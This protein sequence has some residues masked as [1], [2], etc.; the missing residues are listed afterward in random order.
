MRLIFGIVF[1]VGYAFAQSGI[2][3]PKIGSIIDS[4]GS[5]RSVQ[6]VAGSFSLGAVSVPEVLS[7]ACSEHLCLAK[8]DS[9]ILSPTGETDA[10]PGPAIFA[11]NGDAATMYFAAP[12]MFAQWAN[13]SMDPLEW[14]IEGDVLSLLWRDGAITIAVRRE[15]RVWIVHPDG[16]VADSIGGATG[17]VML[18][19]DGVLFAT[20]GEIVLRHSDSTEV[21]FEL[22]DAET[23]DAMGPHYAVIHADGAIYAFR[24][25]SGQEGVFMLPGTRP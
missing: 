14:K 1:C 20:A 5:L 18:L 11:M 9:K 2:E 21:R 24:T 10:P 6:G 16:S 12:H 7:A 3:V 4:S 17:P 22:K 8:T 15:G 25:D 13:D 19:P 23:I